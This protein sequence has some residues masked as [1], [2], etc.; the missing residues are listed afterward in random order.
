MMKQPFF[1]I[2]FAWLMLAGCSSSQPQGN[3]GKYKPV[4]N[5]HPQYF[6][7]IK[8]NPTLSVSRLKAVIRYVAYNQHCNVVT[9]KFEGA[10]AYRSVDL[11]FTVKDHQQK[12]LRIPFDHYLPGFCQWYGY[13]VSLSLRDDNN[14]YHPVT[15][16][17]IQST[18]DGHTQL[19]KNSTIQL[20]CKRYNCFHNHGRMLPYYNIP[21]HQGANINI[22]NNK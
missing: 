1:V 10:T 14:H 3:T 15:N 11:T 13:S 12:E 4:I 6:L 5:P 7:V 2:C 21:F 8:D 19:G 16:I 18:L 20:T 9:N 17:N 22:T